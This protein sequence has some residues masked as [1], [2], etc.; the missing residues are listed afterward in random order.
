MFE[1]EFGGGFKLEHLLDDAHWTRIPVLTSASVVAHA[2]DMC[3]RPSEEL[4]TGSTGGSW[5]SR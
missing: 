3:T 4:D 5:A 1:G 2:H